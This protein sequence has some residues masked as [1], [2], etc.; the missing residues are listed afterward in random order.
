MRFPN[1]NSACEF[2]T[3]NL[4]T[5]N[6][7]PKSNYKDKHRQL[8]IAVS[9]CLF[10]MHHLMN[11]EAEYRNFQGNLVKILYKKNCNF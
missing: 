8:F 7:I 2:E 10:M 11:L 3:N 9:F 1:Y 5:Q 4:F 6:M